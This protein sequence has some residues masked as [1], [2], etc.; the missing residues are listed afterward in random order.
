MIART[1]WVTAVALLLPFMA[2]GFVTPTL[3]QN[4]PSTLLFSKKKSSK[5]AAGQGFGK[6][7]EVTERSQ[8]QPQPESMPL[9]SV[10]SVAS[11][12]IPTM[13]EPKVDPSLPP[14]E[15]TK[16][17]LREKY[18]LKSLDEQQKDAAKRE[19]M[20][21]DRRKREEWKKMAEKEDL[22]IMAIIPAPILIAIDRFLKIGVGV[23]TVLFVAAAFAIAVEAWS[24]AT[25]NPLPEDIDNFI[26]TVVEPNFTPG[27]LVLLSFSVSLGIFASLQLG[28][29]G[30]QYREDK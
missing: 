25:K 19:R 27:L 23:C 10:N 7:P 1:H 12:A 24:A 9:E 20:E 13:P 18:G 29:E 15:R 4:S 8:P 3:T 21:E 5:K 28:S 2:S 6:A 26:V 14:E 11:N 16:Q 30:A 22:D 17:L